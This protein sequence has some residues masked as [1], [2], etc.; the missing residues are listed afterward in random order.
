MRK[1]K[2][3]AGM[4]KSTKILIGLLVI[5]LVFFVLFLNRENL[6]LGIKGKNGKGIFAKPN[7]SKLAGFTYTF[8]GTLGG[9][10]YI[11]NIEDNRFTY[12]L[13]HD[14]D[15][16]YAGYFVEVDD[17]LLA[18][19]KALYVEA[20]SYRWDGYDKRAMNVLDGA[21]F[22]LSFRFEDGQTC[23]ASGMNCAPK[24]YSRF[25][26]GMQELLRP[27]AEEII[28]RAEEISFTFK[29]EMR[30]A[31]VWIIHNTKENHET[32]LWGAATISKAARG[33][34]YAVTVPKA[35]NN[36]YLLRMIDSQGMYYESGAIVLSDGDRVRVYSVGYETQLEIADSTGKILFKQ[37]IFSAAL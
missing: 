27:L 16:R 5:L 3:E 2:D 35:K 8:I 14:R 29:N 4:K 9:P 18:K 25:R 21:G 34:E 17:E 20:K 12:E 22:S 31:D 7:S 26:E 32:T 24:N 11:Y 15:E 19:I 37:T 10:G 6:I 30:E 23:A 13:R 33:T 28:E 1:R 36:E